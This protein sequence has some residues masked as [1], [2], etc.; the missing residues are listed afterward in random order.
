MYVVHTHWHCPKKRSHNSNKFV[1]QPK[2]AAQQSNNKNNHNCS[3]RANIQR[4][5]SA[6]KKWDVKKINKTTI[7][8]TTIL[9]NC[10]IYT[11]HADHDFATRVSHLLVVVAAIVVVIWDVFDVVVVWY[12]GCC[13]ARAGLLICVPLPHKTNIKAKL[14]I[15]VLL[16]SK[17]S[18]SSCCYCLKH[19]TCS[20]CCCCL[21]AYSEKLCNCNLVEQV[22]SF[23]F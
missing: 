21:L 5:V 7:A 9:I 8:T 11:Q 1:R 6:K 19:S 18:R 17:L 12:S 22:F 10:K 20:C 13:Q 23:L 3:E 16:F 2:T 14:R 4:V 15:Y